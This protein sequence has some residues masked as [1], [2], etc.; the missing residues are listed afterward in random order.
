MERLLAFIWP[1]RRGRPLPPLGELVARL[2]VKRVG[3]RDSPVGARP[4]LR[5]LPIGM[6]A[7]EEIA[8]PGGE[9]GQRERCPKAELSL[10][11]RAYRRNAWPLRAARAGRR[12]R[13]SS[14]EPEE[15]QMRGLSEREVFGL[16]LSRR[17]GPSAAPRP[18]RAQTPLCCG[19][20]LLH[21]AGQPA[22]ARLLGEGRRDDEASSASPSA[23][24]Q[25]LPRLF[26]S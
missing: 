26:A 17:S 12:A 23:T 8:P 10:S 20:T 25:S 24:T 7:P 14:P 18:G 9:L 5:G 13:P 2:G 11:R 21:N 3:D 1:Q 19:Q 15:G 4:G 22:A 16:R 6:I